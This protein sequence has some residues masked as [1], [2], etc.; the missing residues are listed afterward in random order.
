MVSKWKSILLLWFAQWKKEGAYQYN[1]LSGKTT[2]QG[3]F[4]NGVEEGVW[5]AFYDNGQP[6]YVGNYLS[7]KHDST[8]VYHFPNGEI[9]SIADF[10]NGDRNGITR[11]FGP[12][13]IPLLEKLYIEGHLV[14]Y[15]EVNTETWKPFTG[16]AVIVVN[17]TNGKKAY[18]EEYKNGVLHGTKRIYSQNGNLYSEFN[19]VLGDFHG[20]YKIYHSNGKVMEKGMYKLDALDGPVEKY[21]DDGSVYMVERYIMGSRNGK[22]ALYEK[23]KRKLEFDFYGGIPYE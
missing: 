23:G 1:S 16:N 15:R 8:W 19:Y 5:K 14:G 22:A 9:S 2:L 10:R 4:I 13:G 6:D 12:E 3:D 21:N 11:N 17:Y 7:G 18:E 20:E